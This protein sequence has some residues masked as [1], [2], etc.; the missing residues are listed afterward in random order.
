MLV[1]ALYIW[2]SIMITLKTFKDKDLTCKH[3]AIFWTSK[4]Q[5]ETSYNLY[6]DFKPHSV[7][8]LFHHACKCCIICVSVLC[9]KMRVGV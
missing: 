6:V 5:K 9:T 2:A 1:T 7:K 3:I 8:E 4:L